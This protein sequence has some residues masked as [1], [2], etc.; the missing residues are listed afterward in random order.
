MSG[1]PEAMAQHTRWKE[2][3]ERRGIVRAGAAPDEPAGMGPT[4][5]GTD[6]GM[7]QRTQAQTAQQHS[8][9]APPSI[10]PIPSLSDRTRPVGIPQAPVKPARHS[11]RRPWSSGDA[12]AAC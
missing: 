5:A 3:R 9:A 7:L 8:P 1:G 4:N 12:S 10:T 2:G 6:A 11:D